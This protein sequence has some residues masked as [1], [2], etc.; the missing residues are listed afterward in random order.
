M[1]DVSKDKG[2]RIRTRS[3]IVFVLVVVHT[4]DDDSF[5]KG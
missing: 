1:K 4:G 5:F 2:K 3:V